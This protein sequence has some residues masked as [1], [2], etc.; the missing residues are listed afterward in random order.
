MQSLAT[1]VLEEKADHFFGNAGSDG[2]IE[3]FKLAEHFAS[4]ARSDGAVQDAFVE[5]AGQDL[6]AGRLL[7]AALQHRPITQVLTWL[8][9][10]TN[11]EPV[12]CRSDSKDDYRCGP[13][14]LYPLWDLLLRT[15]EGQR[16][17]QRGCPLRLG[18]ATT[19]PRGQ[20]MGTMDQTV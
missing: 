13:G 19:R 15:T 20:G 16:G 9:E 10:P 7:A 1:Q 6:L 14:H 4:S 11:Q 8:S 17:P 12:N 18:V 2:F 5:P 3:A